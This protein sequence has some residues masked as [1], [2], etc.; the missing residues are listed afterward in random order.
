MAKAVQDVEVVN[1]NGKVVC[2]KR[3]FKTLFSHIGLMGMVLGYA[4]AGALVFQTLESE[5]EIQNC[6]SLS[7]KYE[8]LENKTKY[9]VWELAK[10]YAEEGLDDPIV[11]ANLM[12]ELQAQ[13]DLWRNEVLG[14]PDKI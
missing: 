9:S 12:A 4:A 1:E 5:N 6:D 14:D 2:L 3:T 7:K 11:E 8:P 13:V 10:A